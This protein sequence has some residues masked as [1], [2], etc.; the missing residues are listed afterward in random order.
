MIGYPISKQQIRDAYELVK[1]D[2]LTNEGTIKVLVE[3][4]DT[5]YGLRSP[6]FINYIFTALDENDPIEAYER[7]MKIIT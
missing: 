1:R 5:A 4:Y 3:F 7:A 2:G 6:H